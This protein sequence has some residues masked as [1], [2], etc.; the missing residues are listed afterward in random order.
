MRSSRTDGG[1][2]GRKRYD[3]TNMKAGQIDLPDNPV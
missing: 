3:P 1:E 2:D